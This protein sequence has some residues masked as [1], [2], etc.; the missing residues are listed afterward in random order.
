MNITFEQLNAC[1]EFYSSDSSLR[2]T[3]RFGQYV[4]NKLGK[5]P[6]PLLFY[7]TDDGKAYD[8]IYKICVQ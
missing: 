7:E 2:S 1:H 5:T 3:Q 8:M 6:W 4:Y